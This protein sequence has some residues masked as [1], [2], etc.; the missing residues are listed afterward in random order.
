[1][2]HVWVRISNIMCV[3]LQRLLV[4][5]LASRRR[6]GISGQ[7]TIN[8]MNCEAQ[9][10]VCNT[11]STYHR[12]LHVYSGGQNSGLHKKL[13]C[14][15]RA[16]RWNYGIVRAIRSSYHIA[17]VHYSVLTHVT[18]CPCPEGP[19]LPS[20]ASSSTRASTSGV[21]DL[22]G[23]SS[24][25]AQ[26]HRSPVEKSCVSFNGLPCQGSVYDTSS[27]L[28]PITG[29]DLGELCTMLTRFS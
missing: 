16:H 5:L 10:M 24:P 25:R 1:M 27:N 28:K 13:L 8:V 22:R 21:S 2:D 18:I 6:M 17:P 4:S 29:F 23:A 26:H 20:R 12:L 3:G 15:L 14:P 7:Q 9:S 11:S 19:E